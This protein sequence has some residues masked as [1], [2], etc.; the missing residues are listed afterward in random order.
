VKS[1]AQNRLDEAPDRLDEAP[2]RLVCLGEALVD[3]ICPDPVDDPLDATRFEVRFGGA[4][5][6][7]AVAARRAGARVALAGGA[8]DDRWGRFI[9]ARLA[10]EGIDLEFQTALPDA[11]TAF[12]F[13]TLDHDG[14]P[15]FDIHGGGI[16]SA[17]ASLAGRERELVAAAGA[18]CFGSNTVV[19]PASRTVTE[20]VRD[21]ALARGVPVLF[22]PNL[23]PNR[24]EDLDAAREL[25]LAFARGATVLKCNTAEAEWLTGA[26]GAGPVALAEQLLGLGPELVVVTAGPGELAARGCCSLEA[27]P[28]RV[29]VVSPLG[30]GDVFMGTLAAGLLDGGWDLGRAPAAIAAAAAAGA[31]ACTCL[32][33]F[34]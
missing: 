14:E 19:S 32:G 33:A 6:N 13:A 18:V 2:N 29:E 34:D 27:R 28:P 4:L 25:S 1:E 16:D 17:I 8:G 31:A 12:A 3:L 20:T 15:D 10:E 23:R 7:V 24:W 21:E 22:D 30:S 11:R 5:S 26:P 9:R